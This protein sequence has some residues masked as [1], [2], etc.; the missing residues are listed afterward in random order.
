MTAPGPIAGSNPYLGAYQT[1][2]YDTTVPPVETP[3]HA[4]DDAPG[5]PA[6][7]TFAGS[8]ALTSSASPAKVFAAN[9]WQLA[10]PGATGIP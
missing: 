4:L 10:H 7:G 6:A 2:Q 3:L 9:A 5:A 8:N 1:K